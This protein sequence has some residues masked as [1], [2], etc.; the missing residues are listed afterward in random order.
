MGLI[1]ENKSVQ[2]LY[3]LFNGLED[4]EVTS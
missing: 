3:T 1:L 2:L 4:L